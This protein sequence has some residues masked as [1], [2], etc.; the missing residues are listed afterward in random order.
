MDPLTELKRA[1]FTEME[2]DT[3]LTEMVPATSMLA[4]ATVAPGTTAANRPAF[5]PSGSAC[6]TSCLNTVCCAVFVTSTSGASPLTVIVSLTAP[7][8]RS[9]LTVEAA[10]VCTVIPSRLSD[11]NPCRVNVTPYTPGRS[12]VTR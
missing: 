3:A 12:A 7:T 11:E 1:V 5:F 8:A 9:A 4:A 2:N 10:D 6:M